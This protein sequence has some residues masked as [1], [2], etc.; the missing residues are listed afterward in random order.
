MEALPLT[1]G[2]WTRRKWPQPLHFQWDVSLGKSPCRCF[3]C[4][5]SCKP[6]TSCI[7]VMQLTL[8]GMPSTVLDRLRAGEVI[9]GDGSYVFTLERRGYVQAGE[10]SRLSNILCFCNQ[11]KSDLVCSSGKKFPS[12]C[13]KL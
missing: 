5:A 2:W 9:I 13:L 3:N 1:C 4:C 8:S 11:L 7:N 6:L 10:F 12:S